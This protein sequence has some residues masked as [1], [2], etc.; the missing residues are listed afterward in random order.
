MIDL[1]EEIEMPAYDYKCEHCGFEEEIS[2]K[3]G[4]VVNCPSCGGELK[5]VFKKAPPVHFNSTGF[6]VT[7]NQSA[8]KST[9]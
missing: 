1:L 8:K 4:E 7:D 2:H 5:Q 9:S 3:I 6:Y